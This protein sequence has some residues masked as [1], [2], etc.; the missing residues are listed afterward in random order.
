MSQLEVDR[1]FVVLLA[2]FVQM[3]LI[4]EVMRLVWRMNLPLMYYFS[5]YFFPPNLLKYLIYYCHYHWLKNPP[6]RRDSLLTKP[7]LFFKHKE[8]FRFYIF[9]F[10]KF[11]NHSLIYFFS[12]WYTIT[13]FY[14]SLMS[15]YSPQNKINFYLYS[16]FVC[17]L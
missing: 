5:Q 12:C 1:H 7:W 11:I 16:I 14:V 17:E 10:N 4:R 9:L 2:A 15:W 13:T 8:F 6:M 3:N